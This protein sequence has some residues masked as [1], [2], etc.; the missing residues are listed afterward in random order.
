[1]KTKFIDTT[2]PYDGTQLQSLYAYLNHD[3]L[4]DSIIA[5]Q[6]PC[7]IEFQHM[8]D[9]EDL[10]EKARI[11]GHNMIHFI[12]EAF[13]QS[14]TAGV[15]LQRL[16]T[17]IVKDEI[18]SQATVQLKRS[19][20]DLYWDDKKLSISIASQSI[21]S[22]MIHFAVN[23]TNVG[24]PVPTCALSDF[25]INSTKFALSIIEKFSSEYQSIREATWK[26]KSL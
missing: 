8:V 18:E 24:T 2:F 19:G 4:G 25:Q 6:G 23:V 12:I 22:V 5:W 16:L 14:L 26:V 15:T 9:G 11:C 13:D 1:M 10:K 3:L 21:R 20:D 17:A 7:N